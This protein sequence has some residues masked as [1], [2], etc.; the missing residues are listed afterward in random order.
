MDSLCAR[1]CKLLLYL[2]GSRLEVSISEP[3][4]PFSW[5]KGA[6]KELDGGKVIWVNYFNK[7]Y[8]EQILR[9]YTPNCLWLVLN[10]WP[11][12]SFLWSKMVVTFYATTPCILCNHRIS[13]SL[14]VI[15]VYTALCHFNIFGVKW[16]S[17]FGLLK[18]IVN[19][20]TQLNLYIKLLEA[21]FLPLK[22]WPWNWLIH[23]KPLLAV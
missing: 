7:N 10:L 11:C 1:V 13:Y 20:L 21:I 23:E 19:T 22:F 2:E 17:V 8:P 12:E 14:K 9:A 6:L 5:P 16:W 4:G 18:K 3:M 15:C